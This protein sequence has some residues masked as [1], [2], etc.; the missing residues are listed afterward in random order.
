M[1]VVVGAAAF[2]AVGYA[3]VLPVAAI[4]VAIFAVPL[5]ADAWFLWLRADARQRFA[6]R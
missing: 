4:R 5:I 3:A 2:K 6:T 1:G